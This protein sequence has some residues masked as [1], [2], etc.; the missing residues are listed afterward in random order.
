MDVAY[1]WEEETKV[2]DPA[3]YRKMG[4]EGILRAL[5]FG[6]T[7]PDRWTKNNSGT[8]LC[9]IKAKDWDGL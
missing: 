2:V 6:R 7:V 1:E 5:A 3:V 9:G 4:D 8:V